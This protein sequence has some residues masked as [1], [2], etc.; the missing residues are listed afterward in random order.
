M[1][2]TLKF[3]RRQLEPM[4]RLW[5]IISST[6]LVS[7]YDATFQSGVKNLYKIILIAHLMSW[8]KH[9]ASVFKL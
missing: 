8:S 3:S 6:Y 4:V 2:L 7:L 5:R 1:M 9:F